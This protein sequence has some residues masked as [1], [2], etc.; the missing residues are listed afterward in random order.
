MNGGTSNVLDNVGL[1]SNGGTSNVLDNVGLFSI[2]RWTMSDQLLCQVKVGW[3]FVIGQ[4][5]NLTPTKRN[6]NAGQQY[7]NI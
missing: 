6:N 4:K 3:K 5:Y 7:W 2:Q 1:F